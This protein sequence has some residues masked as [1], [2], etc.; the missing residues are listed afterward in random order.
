MLGTSRD[1]MTG[2]IAVISAGRASRSLGTEY[3]GIEV[4]V[5]DSRIPISARG[6]LEG[7]FH[8]MGGWW[9]YVSYHLARDF[10]PDV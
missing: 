7:T 10:R 9:Y 8:R 6:E 4:P 2:T 5:L 1:R 3:L